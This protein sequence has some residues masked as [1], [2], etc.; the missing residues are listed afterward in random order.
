VAISR[1]EDEADKIVADPGFADLLYR[2]RK[3]RIVWRHGSSLGGLVD[4]DEQRPGDGA[5][6]T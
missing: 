5:P 6:L 1:L 3:D 4:C 2:T